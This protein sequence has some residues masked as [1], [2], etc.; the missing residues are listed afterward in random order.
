MREETLAT[1]GET[2]DRLATT[3]LNSGPVCRLAHAEGE[4]QMV[5]R[6]LL[7]SH[8]G[9]PS[10]VWVLTTNETAPLSPSWVVAITSTL[11]ENGRRWLSALHAPEPSLPAF[12]RLCTR[13]G[14]DN[15]SLADALVT[16][17]SV[18]SLRGRLKDAEQMYRQAWRLY[19]GT[20]SW[21]V[22]V[23][24]QGH[25]GSRAETRAKRF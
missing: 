1:L 16:T 25:M 19:V 14:L 7:L 10:T 12:E 15:D 9:T 23:P 22:A 13:G 8:Q 18:T 5:M 4:C 24:Q 17:G 20:A 11:T 3:Q 21:A 2:R 6:A